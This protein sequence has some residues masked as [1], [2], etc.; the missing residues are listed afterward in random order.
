MS[1]RRLR[2]FALGL[3]LLC[4]S[5][6]ARAEDKAAD[7]LKP[8]A[9]GTPAA[10]VQ[11]PPMSADEMKAAGDHATQ[12]AAKLGW[13]IGCQAWTFNKRSLFDTIDQVH[14]LGLHYLEAFPGQ[15]VDKDQNVKMGPGLSADNMAAIKKKLADSDVKLISFGVTGIPGDEAG[16]R[17][18]FEWA[19]EM[20]L[21]TIVSEP[22]E[23]QFDVLNKLVEEFGI[24]VALH[25]HPNP[26]HYWNPDTVLKVTEGRSKRIGSCAD[27]GHWQRSGIA[28][29]E[30]MKK[31]EGRMIESHFK[32]LNQFGAKQAFDVPWGTGTGGAK[33]MMEEFK[34][35]GAKMT[36][37]VEYEHF[38]P[39]L[40]QEV[41]HSIKFF[42]DTCD[43]LATGK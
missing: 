41:A 12:A 5:P 24:N 20:G 35:Q 14:A 26:S 9:P 11:L 23:D 21:E 19:K 36:Y 3:S 8:A 31:L 16:A 7:L 17:K 34:R 33:A 43:Q 6:L 2:C 42:G 18:F 27:V 29:L 28:P 15:M 30:A 37:L 22:N 1:N 13:R 39:G 32:D 10:P 4:L 38:T 25:N 40:V